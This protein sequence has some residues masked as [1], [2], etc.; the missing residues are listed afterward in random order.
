MKK[1]N[2]RTLV[3]IGSTIAYL[4]FGAA[5]FQALESENEM[6]EQQLIHEAEAEL[7]R[8]FNLTEDNY[9]VISDTVRRS[10]SHKA[11]V[12]WNFTGSFYFVTT[13]IT[14]IGEFPLIFNEQSMQY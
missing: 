3:L 5:V 9:T 7:C 10:I 12:Q 4:L 2:A 8:R 14:T 13:V 6:K 1:Q 11:G